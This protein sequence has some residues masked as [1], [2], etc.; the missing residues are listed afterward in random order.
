MRKSD[1]SNI[2]KYSEMV[3]LI[4]HMLTIDSKSKQIKR[5]GECFNNDVSSAHHNLLNSDS[6]TDKN[7]SF[8]DIVFIIIYNLHISY[9]MHLIEFVKLI[10]KIDILN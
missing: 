10:T 8:I 4:K 2:Y 6:S 9:T 3:L 7:V 1:A 5:N